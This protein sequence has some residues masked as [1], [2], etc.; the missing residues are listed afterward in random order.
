[1]ERAPGRADR[2]AL[3]SRDPL[4]L[5]EEGRL[6]L[7]RALADLLPAVHAV[8]VERFEAALGPTPADPAACEIDRWSQEI[9]RARRESQPGLAYLAAWLDEQRPPPPPR[10]AL[11]HGDFRPANV[12]VGDD[13]RITALLDWEFAH[14]GDPAEDL[15]WYTTP[16]YAQ[17][18]GIPDRWST[19]DFLDRCGAGDVSPERL[20]F[21]QVLALFKLSAIALIGVA[22]FLSA[23]SDRASGPVDA[24]V[25]TAVAATRSPSRGRT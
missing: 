23:E 20:R 8:D 1:M 6:N 7:A 24:L 18:H 11:V 19:Q 13:G 14:L 17:E 25:R 22:S 4:R 2:A 12:L 5:G 10:P 15:G 3:R 9:E 16:L 21:W